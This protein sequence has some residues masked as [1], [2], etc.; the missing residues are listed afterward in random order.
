LHRS[1][2]G[3]T[4][5]SGQRRGDPTNDFPGQFAFGNHIGLPNGASTR[6]ADEPNPVMHAGKADIGLR[7]IVGNDQVG[8][9]GGQ[10]GAGVGQDIGGFGGK[11]ERDKG[12][13]TD[14]SVSDT[15][16]RTLEPVSRCG[17]AN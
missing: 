5:S 1:P 8:V 2:F 11:A 10:F 9:F 4:A 16:P 6:A 15:I 3:K 13:V 7:D 14:G 12:S 17:S